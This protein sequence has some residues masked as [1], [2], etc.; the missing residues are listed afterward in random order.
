MDTSTDSLTDYIA[1]I[2]AVAPLLSATQR[3]RL[4]ALL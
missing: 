2:V 1:R 3:E 4:G